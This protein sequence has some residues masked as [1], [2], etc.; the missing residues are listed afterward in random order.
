[1]EWPILAG[2]SDEDRRRVL[3]AARRRTFARREVLF[4][5]GDP[6]DTVHLIGRG[7][8]AVRITTAIGNVAT[9]AVVGP[10]DVVG[11]LALISGEHE[12]SATVVTLER[13][14]TLALRRA[15]FDELRRAH[16]PID[17]FLLDLLAG[18]LRRM[19]ALLVEA[20]FVPAE[21]RVVRRLL[22]VAEVYGSIELGSAVPRTQ[23]VL[24]ST[25]GTSRAT[26]NRVRR[27]AEDS[28]ELRLVRG[29]IE[30]LDPPALE[31]RGR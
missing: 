29:R 24:A 14:E 25:A 23:G 1:M 17:R 28:G 2:L 20:L 9:L 21:S 10:G 11:E 19:N 8:V 6:G 31:R 5:E 3:A 13:T 26:V 16:P 30:L 15:Q 22:A 4:H 7:R 27:T 12:R 18:Q